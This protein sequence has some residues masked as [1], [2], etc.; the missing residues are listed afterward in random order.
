LDLSQY[1]GQNIRLRWRAHNNGQDVLTFSWFIDN[2]KVIA[3]DTIPQSVNEMSLNTKIYPNPADNALTISANDDIQ[4]ISIYNVL[5]V[6]MMEMT[7]NNKEAVIDLSG[8]EKGMYLID[9][10]GKNGRS[11]KS[12]IKK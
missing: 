4:Q 2:V 6:K 9:I 7:V 8:F 10:Q 5:S 3:T 11:I 1:Q 12:F